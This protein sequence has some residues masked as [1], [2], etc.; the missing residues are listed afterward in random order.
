M[1]LVLLAPMIAFGQIGIGGGGYGSAPDPDAAT[2]TEVAAAALASSN[3][4]DSSIAD[5]S[6]A[7]GYISGVRVKYSNTTAVT[8]QVGDGWCNGSYFAVTQDIDHAMTSLAA[9]ADF[10]YIYLDDDAST[11]PSTLTI[12]DSTTEPAVDDEKG[13]GWYNGDDRCLGTVYSAA[14]GATVASYHMSESGYHTLSSLLAAASSMNP[15]GTWQTPDDAET[16]TLLPVTAN[17]AIIVGYGADTGSI[18]KFAAAT[19]ERADD[20]I[21]FGSGDIRVDGASIVL[22]TFRIAL[23]P[24]RNLR[25]GGDNDDDNVLSLW[26]LGWRD[27]R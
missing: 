21:A 19:K 15:D 17:R 23:G 24:S 2:S 14:G 13:G 25:I 4:T 9:G 6:D 22:Q 18:G 26:I 20:V 10:H 7:V 5:L 1:I 27:A 12:I 11:Y 8:V 16:S 3:Y